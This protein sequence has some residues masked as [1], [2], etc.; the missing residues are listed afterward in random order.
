MSKNNKFRQ[1]VKWF[2]L[3]GILGFVFLYF[4]LSLTDYGFKGSIQ[5]AIPKKWNGVYK[6]YYANGTLKEETPYRFGR[7]QGPEKQYYEEG[8]LS[9]I[10]EY[11]DGKARISRQYYPSGELMVETFYDEDGYAHGL[12]RGYYKDGKLKRETIYKN[13]KWKQ[14][15]EYYK[16]GKLKSEESS[17]GRWRKEYDE[18]GKV[19]YEGKL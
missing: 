17:E 14:R 5:R 16:D 10:K 12:A 7:K 19:I 9:I 8:S 18:Q 1:A 2:L 15:K 3:L 13:G 6:E 4:K 11:K